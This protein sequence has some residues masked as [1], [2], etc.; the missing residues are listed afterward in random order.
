M[1]F[2]LFQWVWVPK[3]GL[4]DIEYA[5]AHGAEVDIKMQRNVSGDLG[6][7]I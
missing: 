6:G 5:Y 2:F 4:N 7:G 1:L 3:L